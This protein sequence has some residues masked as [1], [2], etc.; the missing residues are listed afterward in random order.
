LF[1][2]GQLLLNCGRLRLLHLWLLQFV[3]GLLLLQ[4]Q[5]VAVRH[6]LDLLLV[7]A[8]PEQVLPLVL[9]ASYRVLLLWL[10]HMHRLLTLP[11][12]S[13]VLVLRQ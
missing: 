5:I 12:F 10:D 4:F 7:L 2:Q 6:Q 13:V 1:D 11:I 3:L 9:E 8:L